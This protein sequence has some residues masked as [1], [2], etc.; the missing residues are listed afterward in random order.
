MLEKYKT[1][2]T[3]QF[4]EENW[5]AVY[6]HLTTLRTLIQM[7][8]EA[9]PLRMDVYR[10]K[11][12]APSLYPEEASTMLEREARTKRPY[13]SSPETIAQRKRVGERATQ[14]MGE[15]STRGEAWRQ[16]WQEEKS[17]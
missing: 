14:L 2:I 17:E 6:G 9:C 15:G 7:K 16:A 13:L 10:R 12:I 5:E 1:I 3:N 11:R 4:Q 8:V